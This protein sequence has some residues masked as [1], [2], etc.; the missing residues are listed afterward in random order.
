MPAMA[1]EVALVIRVAACL[2]LLSGALAQAKETKPPAL[3]G[4]PDRFLCLKEVYGEVV[5]G[6]RIDPEK[7]RAVV[8]MKDGTT[9]PWDDGVRKKDFQKLLNEPDLEDT[10]SIAYPVGVEYDIPATNDDPG[11]IRVD[12]FMK[13]LYG[14]SPQE[15]RKN[16]VEVVWMPR[17]SGRKLEFQGRFGAAEALRKVSADLDR[18]PAKLLKYVTVTAG[19]FRWRVIKG[20]ERLSAHSFGIA[21]DI[22]VKYTNYWRWAMK[23]DPSLPYV[24][25]IPLEIVEVFEK[26]G[27]IWGGK[28]FHYDTMLFEFRPELF[29]PTCIRK[30]VPVPEGAE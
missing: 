13:A 25:R 17:H 16:L 14:N 3:E 12:A 20:T 4:V 1:R 23:K 8:V 27:F 19:T 7:K 5:E 2:C 29:H 11:R 21:I 24:N 28:W 22:N 10:L 15:V 18:L 26:H 9:I 30:A 6:L